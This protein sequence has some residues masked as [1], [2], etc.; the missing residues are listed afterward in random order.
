MIRPFGAFGE[1]RTTRSSQSIIQGSH[2]LHTD[3]EDILICQIPRK[4]TKRVGTSLLHHDQSAPNPL[5]ITVT[6]KSQ[7]ERLVLS[8]TYSAESEALLI[9]TCLLSRPSSMERT[10]VHTPMRSAAIAREIKSKFPT[11]STWPV[12]SKRWTFQVN[13]A[14]GTL[15]LRYYCRSSGS[16]ESLTKCIFFMRISLHRSPKASQIDQRPGEPH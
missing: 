16:S 14:T 2:K 5:P 10:T 8:K 9:S 3:F 15:R 4:E 6:P 1:R 7:R 13:K 11:P 12:G